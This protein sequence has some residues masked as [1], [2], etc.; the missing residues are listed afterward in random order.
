MKTL[1]AIFY[2]QH[3]GIEIPS[4]IDNGEDCYNRLEFGYSFPALLNKAKD[5]FHDLDYKRF[6][7]AFD[8]LIDDGCI[9]P[10]YMNLTNEFGRS[11]LGEVLSCRGKDLFLSYN[12]RSICY[13]K[14]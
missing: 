12:R 9:V 5:I 8:Y 7:G 1:Q 10:R 4:R 3:K 11:I 13:L 14:R 6:H 2:A